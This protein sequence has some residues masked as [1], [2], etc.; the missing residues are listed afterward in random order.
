[1]FNT[2]DFPQNVVN[3]KVREGEGERAR[4]AWRRAVGVGEEG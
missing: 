1:M 4:G 2:Y 3:E